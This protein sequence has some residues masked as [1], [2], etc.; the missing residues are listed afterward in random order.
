M[1]GRCRS[2]DKINLAHLIKIKM[3][4]PRQN[5][6]PLLSNDN[7]PRLCYTITHPEGQLPGLEINGPLR[8]SS[9]TNY[10]SHTSGKMHFSWGEALVYLIGTTSNDCRN[11]PLI[12]ASI[13]LDRGEDIRGNAM[14][15]YNYFLRNTTLCR[16]YIQTDATM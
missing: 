7:S 11:F 9:R 3:G 16:T 10:I 13:N 14:V 6:R 8:K 2:N 4:I 15:G 12:L 1:P 5:Y